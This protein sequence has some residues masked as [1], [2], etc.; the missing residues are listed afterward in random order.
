MSLRCD[1]VS[2]AV[3]HKKTDGE[4]GHQFHHRFHR[5]GRDHAVVS[6]V[7]IEIP[8]TEQDREQGHPGGDPERRRHTVR[9]ARDH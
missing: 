8:G 5:N 7:R 2:H 9:L 3:D 6:L 1:A 4:Q